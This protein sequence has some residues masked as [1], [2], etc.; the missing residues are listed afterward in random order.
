MFH[1]PLSA[2]G[3][4]WLLL[5]AS[6]PVV[7][8]KDK[9]DLMDSNKADILYERMEAKRL[10]PHVTVSSHA[11]GSQEAKKMASW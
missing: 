7:M 1:S 5:A 10:P 4:Q 11:L 3:G 6:L 9:Q 2:A 8:K